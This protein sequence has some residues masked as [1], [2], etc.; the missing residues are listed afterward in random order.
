ME[1]KRV[2]KS[3][4]EA[5]VFELAR[6][7]LELGGGYLELSESAFCLVA[8]CREVDSKVHLRPDSH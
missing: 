1:E 5:F 2:R 8:I 3:R 4:A 6:F 7:V